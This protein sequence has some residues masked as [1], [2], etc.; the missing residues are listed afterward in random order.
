[1]SKCKDAVKGLYLVQDGNRAVLLVGAAA[2]FLRLLVALFPQ[3]GVHEPG[4]TEEGNLACPVQARLEVGR[5]EVVAKWAVGL[6]HQPPPLL[7]HRLKLQKLLL[8]ETV[9]LEEPYDVDM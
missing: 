6:D 3:L 7:D 5:F 2:S 4:R 1:M 8:G 9:A